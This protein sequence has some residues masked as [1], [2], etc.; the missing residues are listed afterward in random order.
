[1]EQKLKAEG[2]TEKEDL[3]KKVQSTYKG[4]YDETV[5][6]KLRRNIESPRQLQEVM[7]EFWFNHFN[8]SANKGPLGRVLV[9][10]FEQQ[11]IRPYAL[12]NFRRLLGATAHHPAMLFYLDNWQNTDPNSPGA[13]GKLK[14]LNENYARE[15]MELHTLGVDGGYTQQDVVALA[16]VLTGLGFPQLRALTSGRYTA[17]E[18]GCSFDERRHDVGDKVLL[19]H[20]IKG[21]GAQ[22]VEQALDLLAAH[23]STAKHLSFKMAQFFV[24]DA[25][26]P[27]L[28]DRLSKTYLR[29]N[30]DIKAMMSELLKSPEF[31]DSRNVS[32]KYKSP[33][34]F[35]VSAVRTSG[36]NVENYKRLQ[37]FLTANG[38]PIYGCQ[39]PDGYKNTREAWLNP[40]GLLK[41]IQFATGVANGALGPPPQDKEQRLNVAIVPRLGKQSAA[42]IDAAPERQQAALL[43]GSPEFMT[44]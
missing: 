21:S 14:G 17:D 7:T 3:K 18:S 44:Y 19:G 40:D 5:L 25:P 43:L 31:W 12:G 36:V 10:S 4:L 2:V 32:A 34:R 11:A 13:R 24:A 39:T 28:V 41:R 37:Q 29:T 8:V 38:Q 35:V 9:G 22:E 30:G 42:A 6:A 26:P 20:T 33:Y 27:P 1:M 16:R 15:L 23:P